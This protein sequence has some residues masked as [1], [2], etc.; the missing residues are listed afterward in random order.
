MSVKFVDF[1]YNDSLESTTGVTYSEYS[2]DTNQDNNIQL[3]L[4]ENHESPVKKPRFQLALESNFDLD[5]YYPFEIL[6]VLNFS[7][8]VGYP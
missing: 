1:N 8:I 2:E 6:V 5:R 3:H 7:Y 4:E